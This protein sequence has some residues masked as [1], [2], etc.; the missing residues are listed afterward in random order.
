ME[1]SKLINGLKVLSINEHRLF[2]QFVRS[3]YYCK[4]PNIARFLNAIVETEYLP[5]KLDRQL[6]FEAVFPERAYSDQ[7]FYELGSTLYRLLEEFL[8]A[9]RLGQSNQRKSAVL[10]EEF[11]E[12]VMNRSFQLK[13]KSQARETDNSSRRDEHYYLNQ[14]LIE[15]AADDLFMRQE[16]RGQNDSLI[17]KM[18]NL[19]HFYFAAKLRTACEMHNRANIVATA[20]ED[21][22]TTEVVSIIEANPEHFRSIAA[23]WAYYLI[24]KMLVSNKES[25][26]LDL[27]ELLASQLHCFSRSE[28]RGLF[29]HALNFCIRRIN[30]AEAGW[31]EKIFDVYQLQLEKNY[32]TEGKYVNQWNYKN[33]ITV[34]LRL[35][36]YEWTRAFLE[37]QRENLAPEFRENAFN[38]NLANFLYETGEKGQAQRLMQTV[39]FTDPYYN[40]ATRSLLSR[41]YLEEEDGEGL[42][43]QLEAFRGF[44]SRNKRISKYQKEV[45]LN[46]VRL[47]KS[48]QR[49]KDLKPLRITEKY[50]ARVADLEKRI[51]G[52]S[53][54]H[55]LWLL[56]QL[57]QLR[58]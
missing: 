50:L 4:D 48:V 20:Y 22:F 44:L 55:Q 37:E 31:L 56:Q 53:T 28:A 2:D 7:S 24:Y 45:N 32:L 52:K 29:Q 10:L 13:Y 5:D 9:Q 1:N 36:E 21:R 58:D 38:Y 43:A 35:K 11:S 54:V 27:R 26:F 42:F 3:P 40:L 19:D 15:T 57:N 14:Y 23:V 6:I 12:R 16:L 34:G 17:A 39:A 51:K 18:D 49:L 33:I 30:Q 41:I 46:F 47:T 25:F 8:I